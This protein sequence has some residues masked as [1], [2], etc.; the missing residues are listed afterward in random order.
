MKKIYRFLLISV[1]AILSSQLFSQTVTSPYEVATWS[2][3]RKAAVSFTFDDECPNQLKIAV[4]YFDTL[5]LKLTLF[6]PTSGS[7]DWDGLK[8][9]S[10][11]GHEI[12][13]HTVT[14]ANLSSIS[15]QQQINELKNSKTAIESHIPNKKCLTIAY[16]FCVPCPDSLLYKYYISARGCQGFIEGKT[17]GN[18]DNI[19]SIGVGKPGF[20]TFEHYKSKFLSVGKT[21]GWLVLLIHALDTDADGFSPVPSQD[22]KWAAEFLAMRKPKY[23]TTTFLNATLYSKERKAVKVKETA[24][25]DSSF[26]LSVT[27]NLPDSI[28]NYPLTLRRPLP[29]NWPST[30]VIQNSVSVPT[31]IVKVDT[32]VYITFDVIPDLGE[33]KIL[34]NLTTVIPQI[35]SIPADNINPTDY[36]TSSN[37]QTTGPS[38]TKASFNSGKLIVTLSNFSNGNLMVNLYDIRGVSM[39]SRKWNYKGENEITIDL[40]GN[41]KSGIYVVDITD[42][43]SSWY[44]KIIV[45]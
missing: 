42:G 34:K 39:L 9:A 12:A 17:P 35:D 25:T 11:S 32:N 3:F 21:G 24:A 43:R 16:P 23:W 13:S 37:E 40:N 45:N 38:E 2:G 22:M 15:V 28:Y 10:D 5:G 44:S 19:S 1:L 14:H 4:P 7:P 26:T 36:I 29:P 6:T 41:L 20:Y 31:R 8:T 30:T 27:D 33:V 18:Y